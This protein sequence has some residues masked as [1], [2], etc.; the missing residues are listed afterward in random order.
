MSGKQMEGDNQRRRTLARKARERGHTPSEVGA[1]LG[2]SKQ[3]RHRQPPALTAPAPPRAWP[4][5]DP[6]ALGIAPPPFDD[7]SGIIRY[8]EMVA[9]IA[10]RG[11]LDFERARTAAAATIAGVARG[12]PPAQRE[13]FLAPL[14]AELYD[15][16][17]THGY[18]YELTLEAF[19][20]TFVDIAAVYREQARSQAQAVLS[21]LAR[22]VGLPPL[23]PDLHDLAHPASVGGGVTGPHGGTAPLSDAELHRA[24]RRLP[25]WSGDRRALL[26]TIELPPENLDR[27]LEQLSSLKAANGRGPHIGRRD[28][29]TATLVARTRNVNAVTALDIELAHRVDAAIGQAGAGMST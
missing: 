9:E 12:L 17:P 13:A 3:P 1:T 22:S 23:P 26:R 10:R 28:A 6:T 18:E 27:V 24:L 5:F 20:A 19:L 25:H 8:R 15:T 14:P 21:V 4:R 2:A 11:G 16:H 29:R 7:G